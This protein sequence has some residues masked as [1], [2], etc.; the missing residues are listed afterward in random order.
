M[1]LLFRFVE[2]NKEIKENIY[3][4]PFGN[5]QRYFSIYYYTVYKLYIDENKKMVIKCE[6]FHKPDYS[7]YAFTNHDN[8]V[9]ESF[10]ESIAGDAYREYDITHGNIQAII[11]E[12]IENNNLTYYSG[13]ISNY[14]IDAIKNYYF[15]TKKDRSNRRIEERKE[16]RDYQFV[17]DELDGLIVGIDK[18][19]NITDKD[20]SVRLILKSSHDFE[21]R[22]KIFKEKKKEI[23][24]YVKREIE[25]DKTKMKRLGD[26][27]YYYC[28]E[29]ILLKAPQAEMIFTIK[30]T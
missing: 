26:L 25:R 2:E 23:I 15:V 5:C 11:L 18:K 30:G 1:D 8:Y 20:F 22:K 29:I 6:D 7:K 14:I 16:E 27:N 10:I 3:F 4:I 12:C 17:Y 13:D 28:S 9:S 19:I 24:G 21:K